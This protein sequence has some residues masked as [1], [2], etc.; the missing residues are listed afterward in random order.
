MKILTFDLVQ[1]CPIYKVSFLDHC[2]GGT[3]LLECEAYGRLVYEDRTKI[4]LVTW[5]VNDQNADDSN[6]ETSVI[7]KSAIKS[8]KRVG[9]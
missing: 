2:I 9:K 6:W 5:A 3:Q 7:L 1:K 8:L 4:I